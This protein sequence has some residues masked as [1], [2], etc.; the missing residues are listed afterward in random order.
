MYKCRVHT[1]VGMPC[2]RLRLESLCMQHSVS[3]RKQSDQSMLLLTATALIE[4]TRKGQ[5][6]RHRHIHTDTVDLFLTLRPL[7]RKNKS[8]RRS[9]LIQ[10]CSALGYK[11]TAEAEDRECIAAA[12]E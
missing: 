5:L 8:Q 3:G 10:A 9:F 2:I 1:H 4:R 7:L 6:V 11:K 12:L